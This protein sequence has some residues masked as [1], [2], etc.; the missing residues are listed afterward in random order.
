MWIVQ[1]AS[2]TGAEVVGT[3]SPNN[4]QLTRSL[5]AKEA[6]NYRTCDFKKWAEEKVENNVD[7]VIDCVGGKSLEGAWRCVRDN[8]V[9]I[10]QQCT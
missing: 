9:V 4:L 1:I 3:S 2:L 8:G 5:G 6:L 7:L 10:T